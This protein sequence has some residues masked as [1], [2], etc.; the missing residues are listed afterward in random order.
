MSDR[1]LRHWGRRFC[2]S[3]VSNLSGTEEGGFVLKVSK[4]PRPY[5]PHL[6]PLSLGTQNLYTVC[7]QVQ[8]IFWPPPP[9]VQT[10]YMETSSVLLWS[11]CTCCASWCPVAG[12]PRP[13]SAARGSAWRWSFWPLSAWATERLDHWGLLESGTVLIGYY[14]YL[15]T[16]PKN[17]HRLIIVTGW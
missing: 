12:P 17:S 9:S 16:R 8:G 3:L 14:D 11:S 1:H 15:G 6:L 2:F 5:R 4:F 7:P 13:F 10:S